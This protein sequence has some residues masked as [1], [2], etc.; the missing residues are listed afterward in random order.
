MIFLF[1][2]F[3]EGVEI[4]PFKSVVKMGKESNQGRSSS[5]EHKK[6]DFYKFL[7]TK[8]SW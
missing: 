2:G 4:L 3:K 8:Y 1:A 7:P 6:P 5:D